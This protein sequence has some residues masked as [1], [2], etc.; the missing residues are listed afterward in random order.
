MSC[1]PQLLN[2]LWTIWKEYF[3]RRNTNFR[4]PALDRRE[5]RFFEGRLLSA[6]KEILAIIRDVTDQS[7]LRNG[8]FSRLS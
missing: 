8:S 3:K 2:R 1:Q 7:R 4:V 6:K 5:K